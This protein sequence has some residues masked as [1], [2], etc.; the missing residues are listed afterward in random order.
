MANKIINIPDLGEAEDVEVIEVC[1]KA[2][3]QVDS[4]DPI[5]VL[6]SDKAAMEIPMNPKTVSPNK[7]NSDITKPETAT[8]RMAIFCLS[9]LSIPW[10]IATKMGVIPIGSMITNKATKEAI[11]KSNSIKVVFPKIIMQLFS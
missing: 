10:V 4:E 2:G 6:E 8:A 7:M 11:R 1:A 5:I 9:F 3:D